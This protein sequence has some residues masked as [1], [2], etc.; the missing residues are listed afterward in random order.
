MSMLDSV[1]LTRRLRRL[2]VISLLHGRL[3]T[4]AWS[5]DRRDQ[6][7]REWW[8]Q[9]ITWA[10]PSLLLVSWYAR[11]G[12]SRVSVCSLDSGRYGHVTLRGPAA[13]P[14]KIHAGGI[15]WVDG[16]LYVAA[17]ARGFWTW[18]VSDL[19]PGASTW[20]AREL[21]RPDPSSGGPLRWSF[22][23]ADGSSLVGGEY[24]RGT[25]ST[26]LW[27]LSIDDGSP[28]GPISL[29][30]E[31]P[32]GMQGVVRAG[33]GLVASIS[34][35]PWVRGSLHDLS[36]AHRTHGALPIGVEDLTLDRDG[37]LWTVAEH[38]ARRAIVRLRE[39]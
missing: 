36:T 12:G 10:S 21:H 13:E 1:P 33:S 24:G 37:R 32:S 38:P 28:V 25:K 27:S 11:S 26:R 16:W 3:A 29:G 20:P 18:H 19:D 34:H 35:G 17:T 9:G 22:L 2:P 30:R 7:T 39:P 23:D 14:M 4:A 6:L 31:G 5:W 8:P 15:A